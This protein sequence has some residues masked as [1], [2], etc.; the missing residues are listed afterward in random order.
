MTVDPAAD[1]HFDTDPAWFDPI[2][3]WAVQVP[4]VERVWIFGS[5]ATGTRRVKEDPGPI[6]DLDI[7]YTLRGAADDDLLSLVM[8]HGKAWR[9]WLQARIP[10]PIQLELATPDD[11]MVWPAV[12]AHGVMIYDDRE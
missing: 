4:E 9:A 6:P 11:A 3:R 2:R 7:A 10:V 5:R 8:L 12:L 1:F